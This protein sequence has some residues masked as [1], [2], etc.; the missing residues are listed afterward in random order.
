MFAK[1][2]INPKPNAREKNLVRI[3]PLPCTSLPMLF[4]SLGDMAYQALHYP[5]SSIFYSSLSSFLVFLE[6]S[7][8]HLLL[9]AFVL[10]YIF[11]RMLF[12]QISTW[13]AHILP[14]GL[15]SN[16]SSLGLSNHCVYLIS[17]ISVLL[18]P[19]HHLIKYAIYYFASPSPV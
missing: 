9:R 7:G 10:F 4:I 3:T 11:L 8:T 6:S 2:K 15:C 17:V 14:L 19:Q 13:L 1:T 5:D 18:I 12:S 16:I